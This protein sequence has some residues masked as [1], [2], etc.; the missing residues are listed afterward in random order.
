MKLF[1]SLF[2]ASG[3]LALAYS[4]V[5]PQDWRHYVSSQVPRLGLPAWQSDAESDQ[6]RYTVA[7]VD[8]GDIVAMVSASGSLAALATVLV[9]SEISGQISR[10]VA[11]YNTEVK[12][13]DVIA[14]ID[15]TSYEVVVE[16]AQAELAVA[17]S[18][19]T[20]QEELRLKAIADFSSALSVA[21]TATYAVEKERIAVAEAQRDMERKRILAGGGNTTKVELLHAQSALD[22]AIQDF[23]AAQSDSRTKLALVRAAKAMLRSTEAQIG[24]ANAE[25]MQKQAALKAA[26]TQLERTKIRSPANGVVIGRTV[27]EGQQVTVTLQSETLFT[28]AQDL[29]EMQIKISVDEADIGKVKEGQQVVYTVDSYPGRE[30]RGDVTQIRKDGQTVQNVVTYI[31]IASARNPEKILLPGMT[32]NARIIIDSRKDV[33]KVPVAALRFTPFKENGSKESHVWV[34]DHEQR[35][36]AVPV[37]L[38]LSDGKMVQIASTIALDR[39]IT[40]IDASAPPP[41]FARRVI[42]SM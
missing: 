37:K 30:F 7:P 11:D 24:H 6:P 14:E 26:R 18:T 19:V 10:I 23:L 38:G 8:R 16:Q 3:L 27:E 15:P 41:T 22:T 40:G 36:K 1:I 35:P 39:V 31:V 34:L 17:K 4:P 12:K 20:I 21:E 13:G 32:A 29:S 2:A 25:V 9:G 42:G 28:V 33:L 5:T